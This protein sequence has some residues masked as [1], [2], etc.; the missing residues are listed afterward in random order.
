MRVESIQLASLAT[1]SYWYI[2][3][4]YHATEWLGVLVPY[5]AYKEVHHKEA[6]HQDE[7][8]EIDCPCH[9]RILLRIHTDARHIHGIVHRIQ[10]QLKASNL[11]S[12]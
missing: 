11:P 5:R 7:H 12:S 4:V 2:V 3:L 8:H 10:P 6:A 1:V 9:A